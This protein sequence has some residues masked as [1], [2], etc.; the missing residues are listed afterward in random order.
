[1][2]GNFDGIDGEGNADARSDP[3]GINRIRA[4]E[5]SAFQ[6]NG[7]INHDFG[8]YENSVLRMLGRHT[9]SVL[10][11][12]AEVEQSHRR[13]GADRTSL[14]NPGQVEDESRYPL[15]LQGR[16]PETPEGQRQHVLAGPE[17]NR[18][19]AAYE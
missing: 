14:A 10:Y 15:H 2:E 18:L 9:L 4:S 5:R 19:P 3:S 17:G 8:D 16:I 6:I 1:M 13:P 11:L 12:K 7:Y